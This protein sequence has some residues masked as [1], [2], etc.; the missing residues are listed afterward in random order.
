MLLGESD[1]LWGSI[2][3]PFDLAPLG[4]PGC[5]LLT[6]PTFLVP[7][8]ASSGGA[9]LGL[10]IPNDSGLLGSRFYCQ[11]LIADQSVNRLG[12]TVSNGGASVIGGK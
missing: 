4:M 7:F 9:T 5:P 8:A 2:R 12:A 3:L 6:P 10:P 11:G 1:M